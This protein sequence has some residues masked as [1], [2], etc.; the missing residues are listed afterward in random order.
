M[1]YSVQYMMYIL[2]PCVWSTLFYHTCITFTISVGGAV[3]ILPEPIFLNPIGMHFIR[4]V[5]CAAA[6]CCL[7]CCT[8]II[9]FVLFLLF[10]WCGR[11]VTFFLLIWLTL[12][13]FCICLLYAYVF[14]T[15]VPYLQWVVFRS[16]ATFTHSVHCCYIL[17]AVCS[18]YSIFIVP[19]LGDLVLLVYIR[20]L[21]VGVGLWV[22]AWYVVECVC[23]ALWLLP[24]IVFAVLCLPFPSVC[25]TLL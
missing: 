16:V 7:I 13:L 4:W 19:V 6:F 23:S 18:V 1:P 2:C 5:G 10:G 20:W 12:P 3:I 8:F 9:T 15:T 21:P 24:P 22:E 25:A 14:I 11:T 17:C